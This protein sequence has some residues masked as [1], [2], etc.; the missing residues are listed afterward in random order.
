[1]LIT[2]YFLCKRISNLLQSV[3][4]RLSNLVTYVT[5]FVPTV[6]F[7]PFHLI[8]HLGEATVSLRR[9]RLFICKHSASCVFLSKL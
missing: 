1:M 7:T 8:F 4:F 5:K 3:C 6:S 9:K 2:S